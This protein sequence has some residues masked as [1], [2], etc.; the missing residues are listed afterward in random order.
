MK[1]H[2]FALI[3][4]HPRRVTAE[5]EDK[6]FEVGCDDAALG[7]RSGTVYLEFD[8]QAPSLLAAVLSALRDVQRIPDAWVVRVEPDELVTTSEIARRVG[9]TREGIRLLAD[10]NR[11]PGGFPSPVSGP[12]KGRARLWRWSEVSGWL[13]AYGIDTVN[14][15]E[16]R[17][18][19]AVNGALD[20]VRHAEP[21][22]ARS[23]LG[24]LRSAASP[25]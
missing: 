19:A 11:G 10:G 24:A 23:I 16:A 9:R 1:V 21:D 20:L 7:E 6:V 22:V 12:R 14:E 5:L 8:R 17:V 3:L 18:M 2:T 4:G 15:E 13:K 25:S